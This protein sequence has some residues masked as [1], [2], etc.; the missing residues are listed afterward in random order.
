M[1]DYLNLAHT[2]AHLTN[3]RF[4]ANEIVV[5]GTMPSQRVLLFFFRIFYQHYNENTTKEE[6]NAS[7][8]GYQP[9][10]WRDTFAKEDRRRGDT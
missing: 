8:V 10:A 2:Q 7:N 5:D 3:S 6:D 9:R 1:W 4:T